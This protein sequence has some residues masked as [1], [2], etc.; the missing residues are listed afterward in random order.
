M[1]D[2]LS[3]HAIYLLMHLFGVAIGAGAAY[4]SDVVFLTSAKNKVFSGTEI[5]ILTVAGKVVWAGLGLLILSG[6]LM[7]L[8]TPEILLASSKFMA[9]MTI[10]GIIIANGIIFHTKHIP[11]IK[12]MKGQTLSESEEFRKKGPA[13]IASGAVSIVSWSCTIILGSLRGVPFSYVTLLG[14]Y[15]S[16]VLVAIGAGVLMERKLFARESAATN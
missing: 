7:F 12:R 1:F 3:P 13:L 10:V 15:L 6:L 11:L 16:L 5:R 8:E 14:V 2:F 4:M 9:K